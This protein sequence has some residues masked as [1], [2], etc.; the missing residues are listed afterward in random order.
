MIKNLT[1]VDS[2]EERRHG[3][4]RVVGEGHKSGESIYD[5]YF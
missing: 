2:M 1:A 3:E 5:E 4:C